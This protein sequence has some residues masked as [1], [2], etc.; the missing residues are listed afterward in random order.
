[1]PTFYPMVMGREVMLSTE[2][3]LSASA[4]AR[5]FARGGNAIDAAVAATFVEGVVNPHMHTIGGEAPMLI[6][7]AHAR[8]VVAINGN[9]MA[10]ARATIAHYRLLGLEL[11]PHSGLLAAGVPAA[12]DALVTALAEFGTMSL[13]DVLEPALAL[14]HDGFPM[15]VGL[16][17]DIID[18][19]NPQHAGAGASLRTHAKRF[20]TEWPTTGR[21]YLPAGEVPAIGTIIKNSALARFFTRLIDAEASAKNRGR[22]AALRAASDR[23]YR[24]DIAMEIVAWSDANGGLLQA[25]DLAAFKTRIEAPV[26]AEYRGTTVHKCGPWSQG[27]VF[28]QQLKILEGFDLSAMRHNSADYIHTVIESA[29]LAFADREAYYA[30]PEFV[31]VPIRALVSKEYGDVRRA[32]V[33]AH[34]VSMEQRPGDPIAMRPLREGP[35]VEARA[36]GGGTIHVTAC[37][38]AGN[39]IAV[40]ASG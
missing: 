2:H 27:P 9:M 23:F 25:S 37:D 26:T 11:V 19:S 28:L 31:E 39:M 14:A 3:Y 4:G 18:A 34:R 33:D 12:F 8:R 16:A 1:M 30:D 38:R 40:T 20:L 21:V 35:A 15:H 22:E 17:G 6:Y 5:I 10:P 13:A 32:L 24:G 29:K 7:S 36:W